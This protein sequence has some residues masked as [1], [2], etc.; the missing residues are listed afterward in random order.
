MMSL[1]GFLF[2]P[3]QPI[4]RVEDTLDEETVRTVRR[5]TGGKASDEAIAEF[6]E[7]QGYHPTPTPPPHGSF[8]HALRR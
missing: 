6:A 1:V 4:I 8:Q 7:F 5:M 2:P 3:A